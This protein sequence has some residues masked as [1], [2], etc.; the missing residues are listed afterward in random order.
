MG[1]LE[2]GNL[3]LHKVRTAAVGA[4]IEGGLL[5]DER[6]DVRESTAVWERTSVESNQ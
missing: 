6:T 2:S 5:M 3:H 1:Q 4:C